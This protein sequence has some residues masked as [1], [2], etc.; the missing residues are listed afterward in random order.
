MEIKQKLQTDVIKGER[1]FYADFDKLTLITDGHIGV[2]LTERE[3]KIDKSKM[4]N[5]SGESA[6][7]LSPESLQAA[8]VPGIE[9]RTAHKMPVGGFAIKLK[10]VEGKQKCFVKEKWLKM[11]IEYT[12]MF[13]RDEK[14]PV[15]I[16]K[17]GLPYGIILPINIPTNSDEQE[18]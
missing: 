17:Y 7:S 8:G 14:S 9:T 3:L 16:M 18:E 11:F 12:S 13:I 2:Y 10:A 1:I 15:L 5:V 6:A 4:Q